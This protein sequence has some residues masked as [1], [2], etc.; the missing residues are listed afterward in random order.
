MF[1]KNNI[2]AVLAAVLLLASSGCRAGTSANLGQTVEQAYPGLASFSLGQAKLARLPQ[3]VLLRCGEVT[4]KA[5]DL[6]A[7]IAKAPSEIKTQLSKNRFFLLEQV[8]T[9]KLLV[10]AARGDAREQ[11]RDISG[12]DDNALIRGLFESLTAEAA[13]SDSEA[14]AFFRENQ[15]AVGGATLAQV[16]DDIKQYLLQQK[17]QEIVNGYVRS[18]GE[19]IPI[20]VSGSWVKAQ[21]PLAR[22]NAVDRARSSGLPSMVDFGS[23]GCRPCDMM[24]PILEELKKEYAGRANILFVHVN[25]E[26]ILAARF[27]IQ[28]IPVQVF[29]D[30]N[31][32][33][34]F[35]HTGFF[36]KE[37]ILKQLRSMGL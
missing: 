30:K 26:Q 5:R 2:P 21:A 24:A 33:E 28:S 32:Q 25:Q 12:Q 35:R 3:G 9:G 4:I 20:E 22:D 19:R 29:F 15:D 27:G 10:Q 17:K 23:A 37:E 6:E 14:A 11:G 36:P 1:L 18:L 31:G 7:E 8:A 16:K 13:V 34:V